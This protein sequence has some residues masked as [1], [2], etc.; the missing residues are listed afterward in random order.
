MTGR[1]KCN[2]C[3]NE[4]VVHEVVIK[5]GV[6]K[7]IHL[8]AEHAASAGYT[9]QPVKSSPSQMVTKFIVSHGTKA[10][11]KTE[12]PCPECGTTF[13]QFKRTG[14]LG[15]PACYTTFAR[16]LTPII[17]RAQGGSSHHTGKVPRRAGARLDRTMEIRRITRELDRAV[18]A[19]EYEKAAELRDRLLDLE[20][21]A[22]GGNGRDPSTTTATENGG[23]KDE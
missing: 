15:C 4:A 2:K 23:E 9:V 8:C 7:E 20:N 1:M 5:N 22:D 18:A 16:E 13:G 19:E 14:T 21:G 6:K 3:D 11:A 17:E 10:V 12:K